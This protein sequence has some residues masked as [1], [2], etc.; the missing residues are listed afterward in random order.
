MAIFNLA[1]EFCFLCKES[2]HVADCVTSC[3]IPPPTPTPAPGSHF[4]V[5]FSRLI[6]LPVSPA[7]PAASR[8]LDI[9]ISLALYYTWGINYE[10]QA[11]KEPGKNINCFGTGLAE[12]KFEST[13][14]H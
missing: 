7:R 2:G 9:C 14:H 13:S 11:Y 4:P 12:G 3:L 10:V 1:S 6:C 8:R 5:W